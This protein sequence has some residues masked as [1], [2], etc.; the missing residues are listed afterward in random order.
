MVQE[1]TS[2]LFGRNWL[3]DVKLDC[4]NLPGLNHIEPMFPSAS[5]SQRNATLDSVLQQYDELFQPELGCYTGEP[6][7]LNASKGAKFHKARPVPY[8]LQS[9]VDST[10]LKMEKDGVNQCV[11]SAVSA[12]P[13]VVVGKKESEDV[14]VCGDF[15]VTYNAY[16]DVETYPMS[17]IEDMHSALRRCTVF[18]VLHIKQ[19]EHQIPIAH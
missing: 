6:V 7:V 3:M 18:S 15:S 10:L 2:A 4:K 19:A 17:Q 11:T 13:I 9:K 1:G 5:A 14:R 8:A 12:A 16:V